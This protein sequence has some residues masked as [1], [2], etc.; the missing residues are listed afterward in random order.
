MRPRRFQLMTLMVALL[1]AMTGL[2]VG[3][4]DAQPVP[5]AKLQRP[6]AAAPSPEET[7]QRQLP[8][9]TKPEALR[10]PIQADMEGA[11]NLN[12]KCRAK[13]EQSK[14]GKRPAMIL[15]AATEPSPEEKLQKSLPP[16]ARGLPPIGPRSHLLGPLEGFFTWLNPF[17]PDPAW[18]Q[19]ALNLTFTPS[20]RF[21]AN[22]W[23]QLIAQG[24]FTWGNAPVLW[25]DEPGPFIVRALH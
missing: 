6:A 3:L 5:G 18:A 10:A 24:I 20:N 9:P 11:C 23:G 15:P 17:T 13:L 2:L 7:L 16:P 14:Q 8:P 19:T 21:S 22:P 25:F 1:F 4:A 12:P